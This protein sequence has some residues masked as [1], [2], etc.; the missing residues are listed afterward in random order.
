VGTHYVTEIHE[1]TV[2]CNLKSIMLGLLMDS[3]LSNSKKRGRHNFS[4]TQFLH[5]DYIP[6]KRK[7]SA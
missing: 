2:M 3:V 7:P 6:D 1:S 4:D 5:P